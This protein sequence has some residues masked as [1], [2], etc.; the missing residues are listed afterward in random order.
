LRSGIT[1]IGAGKTSSL[2]QIA[3]QVLGVAMDRIAVYNSDS[4]TTPLAGT[5]TATRGL[6]MSG[7]AVRLA[8]QAVRSRLAKRA[9]QLFGA[10]PNNIDF[11]D[12]TVFVADDHDRS[13]ALKE[14]VGICASEGIH[15]SELAIFRAP[16]GDWINAETGQGRAHPDYT[17]GAHAVEVAVDTETGEVTI[18][19]SVGAHDVGQAVNPDAVEGQ[20]E[21]GAAQG[22]GYALSEELIYKEGCLVTP[23]LSE[24]LCPT[25]M[26]H[27]V[28]QR[29]S[30]P[31]VHGFAQD[32]VYH[33][34]IAERTW[35]VRSQGDRRTG[36]H[37]GCGGRG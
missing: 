13:I 9:A 29:I 8:A 25:S 20:I 21:G 28:A 34:R 1:D 17:Y 35:P 32:S 7:N 10:E 3:G 36:P 30:L 37:A 23:S 14:L 6:Y 12:G 18:L 27:P 5:S 31:D 11:A 24:Y 15:R 4:S 33:P 26:S 22:H 19:K 2:A 16:F